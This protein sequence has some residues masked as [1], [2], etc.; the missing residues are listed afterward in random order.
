[1]PAAQGRALEDVLAP[2]D[3]INGRA[4]AASSLHGVVAIGG[5]SAGVLTGPAGRA[6]PRRNTRD[7]RAVCR[8]VAL[9]AAACIDQRGATFVAV[10]EVLPAHVPGWRA[11]G[12][13]VPEV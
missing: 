7:V 6:I 9:R 4:T 5:R 1:G 13:E 2:P 8:D 12:G 3:Q 10:A 11:D